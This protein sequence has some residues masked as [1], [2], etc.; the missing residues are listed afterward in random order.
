MKQDDPLSIKY[1]AEYKLLQKQHTQ[2]M[3]EKSYTKSSL[4]TTS[5][6]IEYCPSNYSVWIDR[7]EILR[8]IAEEEYRIEEE[9]EWI[10]E[11]A[12]ENQKNYQ[13]WH[14]FKYIM[15][16]TKYNIAEDLDILEIAKKEPK[17]IHFWG[18][19]LECTEDTESALEYTKYFIEEDVRNNSAYSIRYSVILK[20][21]RLSSEEIEKEKNFL[22]S[23]PI[24]KQNL[25][26]WNYAYAVDKLFPLHEI[27]SSCE[28]ALKSKVVPNYY[29][30]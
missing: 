17:N 11:Q 2:N 5:L 30:D 29:E 27:F 1:P 14:H 3:K 13:V 18:A 19:F 21:R 10:K 6:I 12:D 28:H 24:L 23:L 20:K 8:N 25:A 7:R 4:D 26:Y 15:K 9:I 22:L 16:K